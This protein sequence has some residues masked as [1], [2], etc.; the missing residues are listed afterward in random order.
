MMKHLVMAL[1][2]ACLGY[3]GFYIGKWIVENLNVWQW[4]AVS[5]ISY[6][7]FSLVMQ[8]VTDY[9]AKKDLEKFT[10]RY[11]SLGEMLASEMKEVKIPKIY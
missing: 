1:V 11:N 4:V 9:K 7:L 2:G 3:P 10:K 5:G 6:G 8:W